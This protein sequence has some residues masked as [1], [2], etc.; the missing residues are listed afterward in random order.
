M[1]FGFHIS[2]SGGFSKAPARVPSGCETIQIF[3]SNPRGWKKKTLDPEDI[4]AFKKK[5]R[6]KSLSPLI[7]HSTYLPRINSYD[8]QLREKSILAL[9]EEIKRAEVMDADYFII[10][11]TVRSNE[12][13]IFIE[14]LEKLNTK[15]VTILIENTSSVSFRSMGKV[16]THFPEKG[17]CL[18]TAHLFEAGYDIRK[19]EGVKD[20][21]KEIDDYIGI[22]RIKCLH[23]NDSKTPCGSK[24]DRHFHIGQGFIG[25]KGFMNLLKNSYI[26]KLPG[27]METPGGDEFDLM[28]LRAIKFVE[29]WVS[30]E[31]I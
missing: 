2:I 11:F 7:I 9:Q 27:I 1:K 4:K 6:E 8:K 10:H 26:R 17:I 12:E 29:K 18:D 31:E 3:P 24:V 19:I 16:I 30:K 22:E 23:I 20:M 14:G 15:K 25:L 5:L 28:N 21:L 13:A